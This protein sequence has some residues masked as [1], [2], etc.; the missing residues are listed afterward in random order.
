MIFFPSSDSTFLPTNGLSAT[1]IFQFLKQNEF[2]PATWALH[3]PFF[4]PRILL[5]PL[6]VSMLLTSGSQL[7]CHF[8][9]LLVFFSA[10]F[11][12]I[13]NKDRH[14][15]S[16]VHFVYTVAG[17]RQH[18]IFAQWG[19]KDCFLL[20]PNHKHRLRF[21]SQPSLPL[22]VFIISSLTPKTNFHNGDA[23]RLV[24]PPV[25]LASAAG[26]VSRHTH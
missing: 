2:S 6:F 11:K 26:Q 16:F 23:Y 12:C 14:H 25:S 5:P 21:I 17:T 10:P 9:H 8:P 4:L 3:I 18:Y 7:K 22:P 13:I 19:C 15:V 20:C 24:P 1:L